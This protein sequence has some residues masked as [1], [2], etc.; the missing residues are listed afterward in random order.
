MFLFSPSWHLC[1]ALAAGRWPVWPRDELHHPRTR[2]HRVHGGAAGPMWAH[3]SGR[4]LEH[5]HRHPQE[6]RPQPAGVHRRRTH[7]AGAPARTNHGQHD[8]RYS[9]R[10]GRCL[11]FSFFSFEAWGT[12]FPATFSVSSDSSETLSCYLVTPELCFCCC[13][14]LNFPIRPSFLH[15]QWRCCTASSPECRPSLLPICKL[16]WI[17]PPPFGS[18]NFC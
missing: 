14:G 1:T 13:F 7:P 8:R 3:L 17:N 15:Q 9:P 11:L 4:G 6:E 2:Q 16:V 10:S 12:T 18:V 5:L